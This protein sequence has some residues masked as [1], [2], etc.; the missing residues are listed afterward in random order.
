MVHVTTAD[1]EVALTEMLEALSKPKIPF[2]VS[3]YWW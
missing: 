2:F 1:C 3:M